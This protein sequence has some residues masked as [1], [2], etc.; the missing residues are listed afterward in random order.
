MLSR[1]E[2]CGLIGHSY[3]KGRTR[4]LN[5]Y[6]VGDPGKLILVDSPG[7]GTRGKVEWGELFDEYIETREQ[8]AFPTNY[9]AHNQTI[10]LG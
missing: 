2:R 4:E 8:Y 1:I 9:F 7:Y 3:L 6:S 10:L 5:F